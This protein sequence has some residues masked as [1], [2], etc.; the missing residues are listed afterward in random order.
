MTL[1]KAKNCSKPTSYSCGRSCINM[2]KVCRV[3]GLKGQSIAIASR[4]KAT[5]KASK[6]TIS[7]VPA[8]KEIKKALRLDR[9][10]ELPEGSKPLRDNGKGA[11]TYRIDGKDVTIDESNF[12]APDLGNELKRSG[13]I[14]QNKAK[15][16]GLAPEMFNV[17]STTTQLVKVEEPMKGFRSISNL[18]SIE[19]A[20][21]IS[22]IEKGIE[23]LHQEG[24]YH[25]NLSK[26]SI[27]INP[28]TKEVKFN[29]FGLGGSPTVDKLDLDKILD[30][31][32]EFNE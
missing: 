10:I 22:N 25:G 21:T 18:S 30:S 6:K 23:R 26:D 29:D 9:N 1:G 3:D 15:E 19:D 14:S 4:L 7:E 31:V 12:I 11:K 24:L 2:R 16:L 13:Q 17:Y 20:E 32:V 28:D 5:V 27:F 8:T